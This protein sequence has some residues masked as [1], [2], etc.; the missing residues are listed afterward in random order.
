MGKGIAG[1]PQ[2]AGQLCSI[3]TS[4]E[5][6]WLALGVAC[7]GPRAGHLS[8]TLMYLLLCITDESIAIAAPISLVWEGLFDASACGE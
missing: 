6:G 8:E 7:I 4:R 1:G 5:G 2:P 3:G